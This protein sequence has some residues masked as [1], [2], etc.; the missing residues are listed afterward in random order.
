MARERRD[1]ETKRAEQQEET[2]STVSAIHLGR[3]G[4]VDQF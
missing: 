1:D 4:R 3:R 2:M